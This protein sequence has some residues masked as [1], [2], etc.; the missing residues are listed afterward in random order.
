M[1]LEYS[2]VVESY[3]HDAGP[4]GVDRLRQAL[5]AAT[6]MVD[7]HAAGEVLLVDTGGDAEVLRL[8]GDDFPGV[9]RVDAVGLGYDS[10]KLKAAREAR[11]A[12]VVYLDGDCIP[13]SADWI[14]HHLE[15]LRA[16]THA[17]GGF[18]R[19][20]GG[21]LG[22]I[23]SVLDFGFLLPPGERTLRC[24]AFNN[25]GFRRETLLEA[26]PPEGPMRCLCYPHAQLLARRGTPVRMVP[27]ARVRHERQPF[28]TE[29]FR[30][31]YD[32]VAAC[33]IDPELQESR[34]LRLGV[35][36]APLLYGAR[37]A[38]D[39]ERVIRGRAALGLSSSQAAL[40][41][42]VIPLLR[43]VDLAGMVRALLPRGSA[44]ARARFGAG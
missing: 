15:A 37:V 44:W 30:Q 23:S 22:A 18:T 20:D 11:G 39:W 26:P 1:E 24:Y 10:A 43:L 3:N 5:D 27:R 34:L 17:T 9:R 4:S 2:L 8:L 41:L 38:R 42:P 7:Q 29:R 40:A 28:F 19:Y 36:A 13:E 32:T 33:W 16:G 21:W 12:Y 6:R 35:L 14:V 25:T 31:G